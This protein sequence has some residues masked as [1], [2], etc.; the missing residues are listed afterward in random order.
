MAVKPSVVTDGPVAAFALLRWSVSMPTSTIASRAKPTPNAASRFLFSKED[1]FHRLC[2][3]DQCR[4]SRRVALAVDEAFLVRLHL[5]SKGSEQCLP[6]PAGGRRRAIAGACRRAHPR[7]R[8]CV[9]LLALLL[10][11]AQGICVCPRRTG[12]TSWP[13]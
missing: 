9:L 12:E 8:G 10:R 1:T 4:R 6:V 7:L 3:T 13:R 11:K 2:A 5:S